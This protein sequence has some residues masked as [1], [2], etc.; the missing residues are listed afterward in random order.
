MEFVAILVS[1]VLVLVIGYFV[2]HAA[3]KIAKIALILLLIFLISS[4]FF[5]VNLFT[6]INELQEQFPKAR[7][8]ILLND[9]GIRSGFETAIINSKTV[10]SFVSETHLAELQ[11]QFASGD[12]DAMKGN[13][14]KVIII[15]A[16]A[17]D[18]PIVLFD[19]VELTSHQAF[20]EIRAD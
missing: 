11:Q 15:E 18:D 4:T 7:K 19:E 1:L 20:A 8:L 9:N 5:G 10:V 3:T 2:I 17:F 6:D 12:L 16:S 14:F 13:Y